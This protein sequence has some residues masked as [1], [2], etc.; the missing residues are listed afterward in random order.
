MA[1]PVPLPLPYRVQSVF[2]DDKAMG[3]MQMAG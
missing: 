3:K 2:I 1:L